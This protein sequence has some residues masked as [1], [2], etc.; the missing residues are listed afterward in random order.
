MLGF[1]S[2]NNL[3]ALTGHLNSVTNFLKQASEFRLDVQE[4][5]QP[6]V[7]QR[8]EGLLNSFLGGYDNV[9]SIVW[10]PSLSFALDNSQVEARVESARHAAENAQQ[11]AARFSEL[12]VKTAEVLKTLQ[13]QAANTG[14][15]KYAETFKELADKFQS[16]SGD[17][18]TVLLG[19][20]ALLVGFGVWLLWPTSADVTPTEQPTS[21]LITHIAGRVA[22]LSALVY[23]LGWAARNYRASKHNE[24]VNRHREVALRTLDLFREAA[25]DD[26]TKDAV[27][28]RTTEAIFQHQGSGYQG[29]DAEPAPVTSTIVEVLR[30]GAGDK[31]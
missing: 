13:E 9:L 15:A 21:L 5:G 2:W 26:N 3:S 24:I 22:I 14:T 25:R 20:V 6:P 11:A 23:F 8:H 17:W 12:E 27:L 18:L 28:L 4:Q 19:S 31:G 30:R 16:S 7:Q 10:L 29:T 1:I